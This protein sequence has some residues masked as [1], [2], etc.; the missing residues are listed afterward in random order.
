MRVA[1]IIV[2]RSRSCHVKVLHSVLRF[3]I[4]C[5]QKSVHNEL[6]FVND[7]PFLKSEKIQDCI[8]SH[9]RILFIDFGVSI[10]ADALIKALEPNDN[11]DII[12]FP[13]VKE[14]IDWGMFTEKVKR[15]STEPVSQM[16]LHFDTVVGGSIDGDMYTVKSTNPKAWVMMNKTTLKKIK[17]RRTSNFKIA[18]K[19]S[20]MFE[21]F[22]ESGVKIVAYTAAEVTSTY[23]HECFGN[24]LNSTG[25]KST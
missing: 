17:D 23:T 5:M 12:V 10:D 24:I 3:N 25:I 20:A 8:K 18:P 15:A 4:Q 22:K 16:G 21:K 14:G 2:T 6:I 9:D 11:Y 19:S 1:T 7:D 13:G